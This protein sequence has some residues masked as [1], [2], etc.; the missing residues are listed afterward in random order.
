MRISDWSSDVCSSDLRGL[1]LGGG[2]RRDIVRPDRR[3]DDPRRIGRRLTP[4]DRIDI[5]H[6]VDHAP[7]RGVFAVKFQHRLK[8][9]EEL[10]VR[11]VL[12]RRARHRDGAPAMWQNVELGLS[13]RQRSE[14]RRGGTECV[15]TC[16]S[17]W[18]P[19]TYKKKK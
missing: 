1:Q 2:H 10:A 17:W 19:Y 16:R 4:L 8:H 9:D 13:I 18:A 3:P 15:R 11:A 5:T 12:T 14:E 6:A 7:D